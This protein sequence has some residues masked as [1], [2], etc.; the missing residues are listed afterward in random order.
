MSASSA[1][2]MEHLAAYAWTVATQIPPSFNYCDSCKER[3][4]ALRVL[5]CRHATNGA[6]WKCTEAL[7]VGPA[8]RLKA[9]PLALHF[10]F[11]IDLRS[12][13]AT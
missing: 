3:C 9:A 8:I 11:I 2:C 12:T 7:R 13:V 10:A 1:R 5:G 6:A 4:K